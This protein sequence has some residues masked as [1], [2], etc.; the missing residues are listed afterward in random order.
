MKKITKIDTIIQQS[1]KKIRVAAYA[2][3][4]TSCTDQ[5]QSLAAQKSHYERVIKSNDEW[6]FVDLYY[7][8]G[9]SGTKVSNRL[10]VENS[11]EAIIPKPLFH[12]VQQEMARRSKFHNSK[13]ESKSIA[14]SGKYALSGITYCGKC[15]THYRRIHWNNRG[16]KSIVWRCISRLEKHL[17]W[18]D[19][20]TID[21]NI[22]KKIIVD[23]IHQN[24][25]DDKKM[26]KIL[27]EKLRSICNDGVDEKIAE[28][29]AR[30]KFL[31]EKLVATSLQNKDYNLIGEQ[32]YQAKD[33]KEKTLLE[34]AANENEKRQLEE[35][36]KSLADFNFEEQEYDEI[37]T[38]RYLERIEIFDNHIKVK[39][40]VGNK[41]E[42]PW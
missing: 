24:F 31:Q 34:Q 39:F 25:M 42:L 35:I 26:R 10:G 18:C 1:K 2:R 5:L 4:S 6:G 12:Q 3:V 15:G 11:H 41:L 21:E 20:E 29:D 9:I 38:R 7:D 30:L 22:L 36:L 23:A 27:K 17:N 28:L 19:G 37:L 16:K 40:K 33:E 8:E 14:Y 32:I 13:R